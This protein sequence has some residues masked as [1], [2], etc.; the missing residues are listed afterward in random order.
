MLMQH[1][2]FSGPEEINFAVLTPIFTNQVN[3]DFEIIN[4]TLT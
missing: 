3:N 2:L 4:N 1:H